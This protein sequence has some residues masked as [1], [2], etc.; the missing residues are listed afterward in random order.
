MEEDLEIIERGLLSEVNGE[1]D[2]IEIEPRGPGGLRDL[3]KPMKKVS[4]KVLKYLDTVKVTTS[5]KTRNHKAWLLQSLLNELGYPLSP[6]GFFGQVTEKEVKKYQ[7]AHGLVNDGIVGK[8]TWSELIYEGKGRI[9]NSKISKKDFEKAAIELDVEVDVVRAITKVEAG[10]SGYVFSNHPTI[11]FESHVFWKE[12]KKRDVNPNKYKDSDILNQ[13][14]N[15][16]KAHYVGGVGEY[17]RLQKARWIN[18]DAANAS[19]SWGLFQIMGNNYKACGCSKV[20]EFVER[21]CT[22]ESEQLMLFV[23][24]IK[25]NNLHNFLM[26]K[27]KLWDRFAAGYNGAGYKENHYDT[28]LMEA[29]EYCKKHPLID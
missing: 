7:A 9:S 29:Y 18:C 14:W 19:A 16:G 4:S 20:S 24:F 21:M 17:A 2:F 27:N 22:S 25:K 6:D 12:L 26:G 10:G 5:F 23:A 1:S 13:T 11:L 8:A 3:T 15:Q 28:K